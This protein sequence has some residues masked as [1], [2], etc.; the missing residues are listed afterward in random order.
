M[1]KKMEYSL[2]IFTALLFSW[3]VYGLVMQVDSVQSVKAELLDTAQEL[4][5]TKVV[6]LEVTG[7]PHMT[8][9]DLDLYNRL[10][11]IKAGKRSLDKQECAH[12]ASQVIVSDQSVKLK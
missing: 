2:Y 4:C 9:Q 5:V 1:H 7:L 8:Q 3:A 6:D 10:K 11:P 12:W